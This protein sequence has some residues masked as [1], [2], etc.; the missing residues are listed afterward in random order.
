[1]GIKS[2]S[3]TN[4]SELKKKEE[5]KVIER[6]IKSDKTKQ[7]YNDTSVV[8]KRWRGVSDDVEKIMDWKKFKRWSVWSDGDPPAALPVVEQ[9]GPA[10][11]RSD[12][13]GD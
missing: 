10:A 6:K 5:R 12:C 11:E 2:N 7:G 4:M 1:V 13:R 3:I 8:R 9:I